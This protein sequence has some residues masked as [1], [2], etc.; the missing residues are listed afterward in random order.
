MPARD[1][2]NIPNSLHRT[3]CPHC[4]G[5]T[6]FIVPTVWNIRSYDEWSENPHER[7]VRNSR[8]YEQE[9]HHT[10]F[11]L[12]DDT[13]IKCGDCG[14][15]F[16]Y[17]DGRQTYV[18]QEQEAIETA[19]VPSPMPVPPPKLYVSKDDDRWGYDSKLIFPVAAY[20][21]QGGAGIGNRTVA[22]Y[23]SMI[24]LL[25]SFNT[26]SDAKWIVDLPEIE[27]ARHNRRSGTDAEIK[28][29][30]YN[31]VPVPVEISP[32]HLLQAVRSLYQHHSYAEAYKEDDEVVYSTEASGSD[33][34]QVELSPE[35]ANEIVTVLK[36]VAYLG[37]QAKYLKERLTSN[38]FPFQILATTDGNYIMQVPS[39]AGR[40]HKSIA[41]QMG[42]KIQELNLPDTWHWER[43]GRAQ[44]N[45]R[46]FYGATPFYTSR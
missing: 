37:H 42:L 25:I 16:T 23:T 11:V 29:G 34:K 1:P 14:Q 40:F 7:F 24:Y 21:L 27:N 35:E 45:V 38:Q 26:Q 31:N 19:I 28:I 10:K 5:D 13:V 33:M 22:S 2:Y 46:R 30:D 12:E 44:P 41:K 17:L 3:M 9:R 39:R 20:D 6:H 8:P 18:D 32:E 43:D 4:G 36:E 15:S